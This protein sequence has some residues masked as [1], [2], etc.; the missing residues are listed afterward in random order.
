MRDLQ[1][2]RSWVTENLEQANQR[3]AY[4]Y[5]LRRRYR[6]FKVTDLVLKRQHALSSAAQNFAA[7][8]A[9]RFEDPFRVKRAL[10][11]VYELEAPDGTPAG[12]HHIQDLKPYYS[13]VTV[14]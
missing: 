8:F 4:Q 14:P 10:S 12:K 3:Q 11:L 1:A 13:P 7:K 2:L 6:K 9:P 5:N